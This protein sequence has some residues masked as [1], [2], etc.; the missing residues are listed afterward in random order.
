MKRLLNI[1]VSIL[2]I[3]YPL[4][5]YFGLNYM[6]P[7][8]M[9]LGLVGLMMLRFLV[10]AKHILQLS[11]QFLPIILLGCTLGIAV[12][13]SNSQLL[14]RLYPSLISFSLLLVFVSSLWQSQSAVERIA[15]IT[16]PEL[17]VAGV[18]YTRKVTY[19]W[20]VFFL[21]NMSISL[22]TCFYSSL[23]VWTFYNGLLSYLL[24]GCLFSI[25]YCVR[26]VLRRNEKI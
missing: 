8:M 14:L 22:Y 23:K 1:L 15:R 7:K 11:S 2:V 13:F 10:Q 4:S 20:C 9:G 6:Q 24:I 16:E 12:Y 25:E 21:I 26:I 18:R 3:A 5:V 19:V 17:S